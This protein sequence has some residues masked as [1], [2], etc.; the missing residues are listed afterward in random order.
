M[1][2]FWLAKSKAEIKAIP[3]ADCTDGAKIW[4]IDTQSSFRYF[5]YR[6]FVEISYFPNVFLRPNSAI[7][8][9]PGVWQNEGNIYENLTGDYASNEYSLF[10]CPPFP[11]AKPCQ[12]VVVT[13]IN[14]VN[15]HFLVEW[16]AYNPNVAPQFPDFVLNQYSINNCWKI[17]RI[18]TMV[19]ERNPVNLINSS[20]GQIWYK[21]DENRLFINYNNLVHDDPKGNFYI[22]SRSDSW[23]ELQFTES[24]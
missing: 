23:D 2:N 21:S 4:C 16:I 1:P 22:G 14:N 13:Y 15:E 11:P 5:Q 7:T 10:A 24:V 3:V 9:V 17:F 8:G 6:N 20:D 12:R 19:S 18:K